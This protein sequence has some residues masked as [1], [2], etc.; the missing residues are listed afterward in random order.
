MSRTTGYQVIQRDEYNTVF[1][2]YN[3]EDYHI[4]KSTINQ[5]NKAPMERNLTCTAFLAVQGQNMQ[6]GIPNLIAKFKDEEILVKKERLNF[7]C[8]E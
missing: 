4:L 7:A 5:P 1:Q 8:Y 3:F 6:L 2:F